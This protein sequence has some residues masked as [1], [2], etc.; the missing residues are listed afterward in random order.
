MIDR[1]GLD[2][3]TRA[4]DHLAVERLGALEPTE[5]LLDLPQVGQRQAGFEAIAWRRRVEPLDLAAGG[6]PPA[7]QLA[8]LVEPTQGQ[9]GLP[10]PALRDGDVPQR[11]RLVGVPR[12]EPRPQ[13][14]ALP[15]Q[16]Q[17]EV[18]VADRVQVHGDLV[19]RPGEQ[20]ARLAHVRHA[21][22]EQARVRQR[23]ERA[24]ARLLAPVQLAEDPR[25][26]DQRDAL[27]VL[28]RRPLDAG[29]AQAV[30]PGERGVEQ[31]LS[32]GPHP[33]ARQVRQ[34]LLAALCGNEILLKK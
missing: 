20:L 17:R 18:V 14:Q 32:Q 21:R 8:G 2:E 1:V 22:V 13:G 28:E 9:Q 19:E 11:D 4:L 15:A 34:L 31:L 16:R 7:Q 29:L 27:E 24:L 30:Q 23:F 26:L 12:A 25:R 33:R 10:D 5:L 6:H 3:L